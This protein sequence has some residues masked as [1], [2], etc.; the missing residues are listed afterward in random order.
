MFASVTHVLSALIILKLMIY[1]F[2]TIFTNSF[3][4]LLK[5]A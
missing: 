5:L 3:V 4:P 1:I 2:G